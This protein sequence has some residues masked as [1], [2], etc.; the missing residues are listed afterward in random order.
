MIELDVWNDNAF[1]STLLSVEFY[2][3]IKKRLKETGLFCT[4]LHYSEVVL[5]TAASIFPYVTI[6]NDIAV[7]SLKP[8]KSVRKEILK[9]ISE[10]YVQAYFRRSGLRIKGLE[11]SITSATIKTYRVNQNLFRDRLKLNT[12]LFPQNEFLLRYPDFLD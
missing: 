1:S 7:F 9:K 3:L 6:I 2:S 10:P 11:E 8:L 5:T 12:D 4:S